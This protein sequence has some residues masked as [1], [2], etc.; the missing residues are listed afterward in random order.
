MLK[1]TNKKP[2]KEKVIKTKMPI[3]NNKNNY[4]MLKVEWNP[5][6]IIEL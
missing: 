6:D 1:S 5:I 3:I 2:K 4:G